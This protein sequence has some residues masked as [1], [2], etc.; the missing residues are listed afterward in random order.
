MLEK[1]EKG[2]DYEYGG[3]ERTKL[4]KVRVWSK[5]LSAR[6]RNAIINVARRVFLDSDRNQHFIIAG[7]PDVN[8]MR[9]LPT[10]W[11][12]RISL[13]CTLKIVKKRSLSRRLSFDRRAAPLDFEHSTTRV[14]NHKFIVCL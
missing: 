5:K 13:N 12:E 14:G 10:L 9:Y 8:A 11:C 1:Y 3:R 7:Q 2:A 4:V 6:C